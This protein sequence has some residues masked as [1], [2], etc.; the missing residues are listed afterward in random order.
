MFFL[1]TLKSMCNMIN[2]VRI[3]NRNGSEDVMTC[4][5]CLSHMRELCVIDFYNYYMIKQTKSSYGNC[6]FYH[7]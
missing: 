3:I 1:I 2:K 6:I 7:P 4:V 5:I